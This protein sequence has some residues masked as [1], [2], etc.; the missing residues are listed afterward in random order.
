M[1]S[2]SPVVDPRVR[3]PSSWRTVWYAAKSAKDGPRLI[4]GSGW[5]GC[6]GRWIVS[7]Q[8]SLRRAPSRRS[9]TSVR[10]VVRPGRPVGADLQGN[11]ETRPFG[12]V[13]QH[14]VRGL[15]LNQVAIADCQFEEE[16][17]SPPAPGHR[18]VGHVRRAFADQDHVGDPRPAIRTRAPRSG[19]PP[20]S[21]Q[22]GPTG[23]RLER[24]WLPQHWVA[25]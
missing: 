10:I 14:H 7:A 17:A 18:P 23:N 3:Q 22:V 25:L 20:P 24:P 9:E 5:A 2:R 11:A 19:A 21:P 13:D 15:R 6:S 1:G 8:M 12:Q 16:E 4:G